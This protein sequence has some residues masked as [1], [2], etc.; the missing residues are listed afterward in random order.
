MKVGCSG[1][2][3]QENEEK[4]RAKEASLADLKA[5]FYCDLCDKQYLKHTEYDNHI[6]SYDH[7]H[8]VVST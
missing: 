6:N 5:N 8:K 7:A 4:E 2:L 1:C 3:L